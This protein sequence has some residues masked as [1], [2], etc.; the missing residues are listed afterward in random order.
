MMDTGWKVRNGSD[1][2]GSVKSNHSCRSRR[3]FDSRSLSILLLGLAAVLAC[4]GCEQQTSSGNHAAPP[5][6]SKQ[7]KTAAAPAPKPYL[8]GW[9]APAA[10]LVL[11]GEIHG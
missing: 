9:E 2:G 4:G 1:Q 6:K 3:L 10:A 8:E 5:P 11:S 7:D